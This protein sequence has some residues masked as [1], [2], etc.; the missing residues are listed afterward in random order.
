MEIKI[1]K[2]MPLIQ[3]MIDNGLEDQRSFNV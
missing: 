3:T 2:L 1:G